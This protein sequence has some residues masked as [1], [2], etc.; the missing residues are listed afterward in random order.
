[1]IEKTISQT[2]EKII[3]QH[4]KRGIEKAL[5]ELETGYCYRAAKLLNQA[6]NTVLITTGFPVKD[7]FETDGPVGAIALYKIL[8]YIGLSPI[9]ICAPPL[10]NIFDSVF[11]TCEFAIKPDKESKEKAQEVLSFYNPSLLISIERAGVTQDG[12]YYNMAKKDISKNTAKI[13]YIFNFASC[14]SI[15]FGDGGNEIGMGNVQN[16]LKELNIFPSITKVTELVIATISNWGVYGV[17]RSLSILRKEDLFSLFDLEEIYNFLFKNNAL[18]GITGKLTKSEDGFHFSVGK[19]I[20]E[21]LKNVFIT[22]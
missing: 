6:T 4:S 21:E 1:M 19:R 3:L 17:I 22:L 2:I 20:I 14:P 13:D 12:K 5:C 15:G 18:D 7:R 11:E 16:A 9:F 10:Y 8:E